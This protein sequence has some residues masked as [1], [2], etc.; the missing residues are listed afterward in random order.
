MRVWSRR[1]SDE[2][3]DFHVLLLSRRNVFDDDRL[4]HCFEYGN[5]W[6]F[7]FKSWCSQNVTGLTS[8]SSGP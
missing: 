5:I 1:Q 3:A 6:I 2:Y 7:L 8:L 4:S